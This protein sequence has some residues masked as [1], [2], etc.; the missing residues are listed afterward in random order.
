VLD[1]NYVAKALQDARRFQ[2]CWDA[3]TSGSLA[4]HTFRLIKERE[5]LLDKIAR[6]EG[7]GISMPSLPPEIAERYAQFTMRP[8]EPPAPVEWH[9]KR[10]SSSVPPEA[11]DAAWA[12]VKARRDEAIER[13]RN[14]EPIETREIA[15][16]GT[17]A[18]PRA[19]ACGFRLIGLAGRAGSGK[20]AV[21]GMIPGAVVL[22][23]A[24]PMYAMLAVMLG[25]PE[26]LLRDQGY[27]ATVVPGLGKTVRQLL[28]T[29][30]T[31]WGREN[32][33][34]GVWIHLLEQRVKQL[35]NG[36]VRT[37]AVAD[38]RF[39]NE[40]E[41][42]R[43]FPGGEVWRVERSGAAAA[44]AHS[45]EAGVS[46]DFVDRKIRNDGSLQDLRAV[47]EAAFSAA[48]V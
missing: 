48:S 38:V 6:L 19:A 11:L 29:L 34:P 1:E 2:G 4:A 32:V 22:Q 20:T 8:A 13:M 41:A 10:V 26:S 39:A 33:G 25:V 43:A 12:G 35:A 46:S 7:E 17:A 40:V 5:L 16:S 9:A 15:A 31:E 30:G 36:G 45:S 42:I 3:G 23:L 21:A 28:Q 18:A 14:P 37:I 47:V 27:K 24:D 44:D